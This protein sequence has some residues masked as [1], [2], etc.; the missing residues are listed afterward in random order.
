M[1]RYYASLAWPLP[2]QEAG[3]A[4]TIALAGPDR[5][6][7]A[8]HAAE[9]ASPGQVVAV[10]VLPVR[11]EVTQH[12]A[13]NSHSRNALPALHCREPVVMWPRRLSA[14]MRLSDNVAVVQASHGEGEPAV[15]NTVTTP[16]GQPIHLMHPGQ[17]SL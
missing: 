9:C 4:E 10:L 17:A 12:A 13:T 15:G 6:C 11:V 1:E 8:R 7:F 2:N 3:S 5:F 16:P 14:A